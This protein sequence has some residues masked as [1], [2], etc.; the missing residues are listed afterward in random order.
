MEVN[1]AKREKWSDLSNV[2]SL[3][4]DGGLN[5]PQN[6]TPND[7]N[8]FRSLV[9]FRSPSLVMDGAIATREWDIAAPDMAGKSPSGLPTPRAT[10]CS[11][12]PRDVYKE[13]SCEENGIPTTT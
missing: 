7:N 5:E 2:E 10:L 11:Y 4:V 12:F 13:R 9:P 6:L 3:D 1:E 8:A